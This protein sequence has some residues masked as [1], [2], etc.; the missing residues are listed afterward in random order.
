M[1]YYINFIINK[2][3]WYLYLYVIIVVIIFFYCYICLMKRK[4]YVVEY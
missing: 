4:I 2:V 1:L 3:S